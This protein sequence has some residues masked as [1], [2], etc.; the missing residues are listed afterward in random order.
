MGHFWK[1]QKRGG[2]GHMKNPFRGWGM[3]I[4]WNH[5]IKVELTQSYMDFKSKF[6]LRI[7]VFD[8]TENTFS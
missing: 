1:I 3:D 2:G 4:F 8:I 6:P 5:T 7:L